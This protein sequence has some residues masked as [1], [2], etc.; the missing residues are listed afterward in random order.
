MFWEINK[1]INL[2]LAVL[3]ILF[4]MMFHYLQYKIWGIFTHTS[5]LFDQQGEKLKTDEKPDFVECCI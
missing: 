4:Y 3:I 1:V 2:F 5:F